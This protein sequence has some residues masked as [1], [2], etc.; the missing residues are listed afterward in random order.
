M[1][2]HVARSLRRA[3]TDLDLTP[4]VTHKKNTDAKLFLAGKKSRAQMRYL[5]FAFSLWPP[6]H[7]GKANGEQRLRFKC[8]FAVGRQLFTLVIGLKWRLWH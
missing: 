3:L 1:N 8:R 4:G 2:F 7:H 6:R 5:E